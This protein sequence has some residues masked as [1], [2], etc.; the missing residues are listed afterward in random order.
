MLSMSVIYRRLFLLV[1]VLL[2]CWPLARNFMARR[3]RHGWDTVTMLDESQTK[4]TI[5]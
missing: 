4:Y 5:R 2:P 1:L 3:R